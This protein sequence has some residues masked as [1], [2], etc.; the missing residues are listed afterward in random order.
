MDEVTFR[1]KIKLFAIES[2]SIEVLV[3]SRVKH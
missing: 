3:E 1:K 2:K